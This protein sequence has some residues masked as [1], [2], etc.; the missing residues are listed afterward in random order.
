VTRAALLAA[1]GTGGHLFPAEAL[2]AEL[3]ARG[4]AVDL[5]TDHRADRYARWPG[6]DVHVLR[7]DTIRGRD[8]LALARTAW[9]LGHGAAGGW[10]L[11]GRTRPAAVVGFGG[12]PSIPPIVAARLRGV[13]TVLHE[14]NAVM[15]RANR[16]L[17]PL[18]TALAT[19]WPQTRR[20]EGFASK[21]TLTGMPVRPAVTAAAAAP[22]PDARGR[23]S[24]LVFGG[25][26]GA[27]AFAD[28]VPSAVAALDPALRRRMD[29]VQQVRPEDMERVRAAYAQA[30]L[31]AELAPFFVDLPAR[32]A[33]ANLVISR[34]GASSVAELATIGRPALLV[35]FPHAL[36]A[37]Q[38]RNAEALAAAGGAVVAEQKTLVGDAL[39]RHLSSLL[40]DP[41]RLARMAASAAALT[42]REAAQRLADLVERIAPPR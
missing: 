7:S 19:S 24:L 32:I 16:V 17:A 9:A 27:Q 26:Q 41:A 40:G 25:S 39:A 12:Y 31:D 28:L 1:G 30:G 13:P 4:W 11:I 36:D 5:A 3:A 42:H 37:D 6:R 18:V 2:A 10:S 29:L 14:A 20:A 23:V 8:P 22:Y 38:L 21:A 35:P 34:S 33:R 15:G